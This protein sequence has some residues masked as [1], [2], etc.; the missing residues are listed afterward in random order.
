MEIPAAATE[1]T[2]TQQVDSSA[3]VWM[4]RVPMITG[5]LAGLAGFL[6]VRSANMSNQAIYNSNQAVLHQALASDFWTEYQADSLKRHQD[7]TALMIPNLDPANRSELESEI[8]TMRERQDN[9]T[10]QAKAEETLRA[11]ELD[12]G[13]QKL[14]IKDLL[15]Y[16]GVAAQLGIALASVAAL[17]RVRAA[18]YLGIAFGALGMLITAYA[19]AGSYIAHLV[20]HR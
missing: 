18:Y 1:T 19:L 6:T 3:P 12:D 8:K 5:V 13:R 17:T 11:Q 15:D 4:K 7:R 10:N 9:L 14:A 16:A 2:R 20:W